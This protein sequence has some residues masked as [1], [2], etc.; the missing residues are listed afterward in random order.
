MASK[1][2]SF[3]MRRFAVMTTAVASLAWSTMDRPAVADEARPHV[4]VVKIASSQHFPDPYRPWMKAS[5]QDATGSGV[6]IAGKRILT[7]AHVVNF[8][9]QISVQFDKS[10]EKL[11]ASI[12]AVAPGIDLA[13]LKLEDEAGFEGHPPLPMSPKLPGTQQTVM[14][15]GYP[16]GGNEL[17]IT[18]GIV[19]RIE[20]SQYYLGIEGIRVQVDAA[21]N[22]GNSGGPVVSEGQIVGI[23][24]S[25]LDKADNI[26]YIIPTEEISIF[27][28]DLEDGRYDGKDYLPVEIQKLEN[29][30]IRK[31]LGLDRQ[32]TGVLVRKIYPLDNSYPLKINDVIIRLGDHAIDNTG[33][34]R[35][36]GDRPFPYRYLVQKLERDGKLPVTVIR[37]GKKV[38]LSVP[39]DPDQRWV[40][41][42]YYDGPSPYFIYG[43]LVFAEA[44]NKYADWLMEA[45]NGK[46]GEAVSLASSANP[47][48]TRNDDRASSPGERLVVVAS[49]MFTHKISKGYEDPYTHTVAAVN[50]TR[51]RNLK[52]LVEVL[53]DARGE[54]VEFTFQG[55]FVDKLVFNRKEVLDA[56]E[57]ILSD[58]GIRQQ[59]SPEMVKVWDIS[60]AR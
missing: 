15:Y 9:S 41:R 37:D 54:F 58:N 34:V 20:F 4:S 50:G 59:C 47:I 26:G 39:V 13:V 19:S 51:I 12:V 38:P 24:F 1:R 33:M 48:Y 52:H 31:S 7:N 32:T 57:E 46:D 28:H 43:P 42:R 3:P 44:T 30:S 25:K 10:S 55:H 56:T 23:V 6:V 11:A 40:V 5:A 27:L 17:S 45:A 18:R 8:A 36:D 14:V 29:P 49:P 22:P 35:L 60:K 21:I 16:E 53:R 2:W